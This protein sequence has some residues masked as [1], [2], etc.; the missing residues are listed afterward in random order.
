MKA[1]KLSR[2][3]NPKPA[4]EAAQPRDASKR[5]EAYVDA[6]LLSKVLTSHQLKPSYSICCE[7]LLLFSQYFS[8]FST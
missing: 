4:N 3:I 5:A 6:S 2:I 8:S 1:L 7:P